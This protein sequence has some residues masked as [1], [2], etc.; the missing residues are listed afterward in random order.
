MKTKVKNPV[1]DS[2]KDLKETIV[3][4]KSKNPQLYMVLDAVLDN[5]KIEENR[6]NAI[7]FGLM[8]I[9]EIASE[10]PHEKEDTE[11]KP[12]PGASPAHNR[13]GAE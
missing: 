4:F 6:R 9:S 13:Q 3:E 5:V 1:T 12:S 11:Q 7:Q 8:A 2:D 10:F